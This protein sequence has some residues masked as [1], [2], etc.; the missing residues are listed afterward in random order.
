[1]DFESLNYDNKAIYVTGRMRTATGS[2]V[3]GNRIVII[4]KAAALNGGTVTL[5]FIDDLA[6]PNSAGL[7]LPNSAGLAEIIKPVEPLDA[8]ALSGPAFFLTQP[9]NNKLVLYTLTHPL[10]AHNI[11][12]TTS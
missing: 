8:A 12:P 3:V 5:I 4:D 1:M 10:G 9:G 2:L 6:L 7:A 11:T